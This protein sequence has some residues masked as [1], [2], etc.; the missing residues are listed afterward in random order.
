MV[1]N[2]YGMNTVKELEVE[3]FK[4]VRKFEQPANSDFGEHT[5]DEHTVHVIVMGE[6]IISEKGK[7][8]ILKVGDRCEFPAGTKHSAKTGS[9]GLTMIVGVKK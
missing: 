7:E 6:L 2:I 8:K 1:I 4:N 5:H 9:E 3:G